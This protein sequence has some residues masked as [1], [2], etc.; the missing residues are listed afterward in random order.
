M[1]IGVSKELT[2]IAVEEEVTENVYVAP[3]GVNSYIAPLDGGYSINGAKETK[4]RSILTSGFTKARERVGIKSMEFQLNVE[5]RGSGVEGGT[6]D[7]EPLLKNMVG[8]K[9]SSAAR[10]TSDT[11]HTTT[12]INMIDTTDLAIGDTIVVLESGAHHVSPI[13]DLVV[14]TSITLLVAMDSAPADNVEISKHVTYFG[15]NDD[16][17]YKS[18]SLSFY[19]GDEILEKGIGARP[20]SMALSNFSTGEIASLDFSG[21]GLDFDRTDDS[22]PFSPVFDDEVPPLILGAC[23][24][25]DGA[26]IKLNQFSF[27]VEHENGF[28]TSTCSESGRIAGRK[29]GKRNI[30]GS[31]NPYMDDSDVSVYDKFKNNTSYSLFAFCANPSTVAG[32]YDLGSVVAFYLPQVISTSDVAGDQ[33]G[34]ITTDINFSADGGDGGESTDIFISMI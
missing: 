27:S 2:R 7:F 19:H 21:G 34:I 22:S 28:I 16:A 14:D 10:I 33:E 12:V 3:T 24:Y 18:L 26:E 9:R 6:T 30:T 32:E 15:S 8:G 20:T 5:C 23:V 29:T 17:D 1:T 13:I 11:G 31:I 4:A 25:I